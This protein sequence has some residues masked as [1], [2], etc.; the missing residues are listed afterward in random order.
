MRRSYSELIRLPTIR[1]RF[2]Y[3]SLKGEVGDVTFGSRRYLNQGFYQST[4]WRN[5]RQ[6]IIFRDGGCDLGVPGYD[7]FDRPV[8]HHI[9]PLTVEQILSNSP[10]LTDPENLITCTHDTHNAIHYGDERLL[11]R[12]FVE[13]RPGDT[14]EW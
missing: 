9:N 13:R 5:L 10:A 2:D 8:I 11:P 12:E 7:I 6:S 14:K 3:L 4:T 1:E